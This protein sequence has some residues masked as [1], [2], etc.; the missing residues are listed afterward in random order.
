LLKYTV[1]YET[2][3]TSRQLDILVNNAAV[4]DFGPLMGRQ[5]EEMAVAASFLASDDGRY[6]TG[7]DLAV[8]I[9]LKLP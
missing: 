7:A 2:A 6:I 4:D 5:T 1:I 8:S 3:L 9:C